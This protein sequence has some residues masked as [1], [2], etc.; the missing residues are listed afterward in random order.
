[1]AKWDWAI[2]AAFILYAS[3]PEFGNG[4]GPLKVLMN[5]F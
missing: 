1:M 5:I 3:M 2:L 4:R